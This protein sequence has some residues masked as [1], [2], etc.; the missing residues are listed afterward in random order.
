MIRA[1]ELRDLEK[2]NDIMNEAILNT[3]ANYNY[4]QQSL[5]QRKEWFLSKQQQNGALFVYE[6]NGEVLGF[7][8][9]SQFRPYPAYQF[10]VEHSI[11]IDNQHSKK[12][13]GSK[14]LNHLIKV[15]NEHQLKTMIACI[16]SENEGSIQFH[17]KHGF[18]YAGTIKKAGFK[19]NRWLD[20]VFYQLDLEGPKTHQKDI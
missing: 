13:I 14:L 7:A 6:E 9:Y 12:G 8:S 18:Y 15:A 5:E 10:T 2:V 3:T 17:K 20:I 1:M 16:D 19:F 11:Y 4:E